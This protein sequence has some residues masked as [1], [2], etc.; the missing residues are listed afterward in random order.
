MLRC[1]QIKAMGP[2]PPRGKDKGSCS[3]KGVEAPYQRTKAPS[4]QGTPRGSEA[5]VGTT[6]QTLFVGWRGR[7]GC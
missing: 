2:S 7:G 1:K 4:H 3:A 6:H 5:R